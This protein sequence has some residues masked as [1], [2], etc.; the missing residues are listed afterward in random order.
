MMAPNSTPIVGI[1]LTDGS[2]SE[3]ECT[4]NDK[5]RTLLYLLP[6]GNT[7]K[8][9]ERKGGKVLVDSKG[10]EWDAVDVEFHSVVYG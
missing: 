4:Y 8:I 9:F 7:K 6:G 2:V 10:H 5:T 3:F 1:R